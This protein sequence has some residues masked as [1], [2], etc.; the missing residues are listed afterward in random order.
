MSDTNRHLPRRS[1]VSAPRATM[2]V[3]PM[4]APSRVEA[5]RKLV[6]AGQYH[7]SPRW[8]ATKIFRAAGVKVPE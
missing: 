6:A 8:L 3:A 5:L 2:M 7:V 4:S 1:A